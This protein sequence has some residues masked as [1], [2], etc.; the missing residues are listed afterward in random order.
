[1]IPE[2]NT[3]SSL[4]VW[5]IAVPVP[6]HKT[7]EYLPPSNA[8]P[9]A[10]GARVQVP[11]AGRESVG[12]FI[13]TRPSAIEHAQ[14]LKRVSSVL[15]CHS[16]FDQHQL[17]L[18]NWVSDYYLIPVG[19]ALLLGL[20]PQ[21]RKGK[22]TWRPQLD[23]VTRVPSSQDP[24]QVL[25]R[26][27][28]QRKALRYIEDKTRRLD[29]LE[30]QGISRST[31][32]A[33]L[34]TPFVE[35]VST[36][37]KRENATLDPQRLSSNQQRIV[38]KISESNNA[39]STHL[40]DGVTG[41][42]KTAIY[43][44]CIRR[45]INSGQQ[46]LVVV[47]EIGLTPQTQSRFEN[48]LGIRVPVI[49]SGVSETVRGQAWSM[50]RSGDA[51]VILGTR[52]SVFCS[53]QSLG[54]IVVDEEHDSSLR[55]QDSPR[56]SARD[57]AVKRAQICD[58]PVVLGSATPSLETLANAL[59]HRYQ[60]HRLTERATNAKLPAIRLVDTRGL[61]LSAGLS[62]RALTHI[63]QTV[64][65]GEQVLLFL[66]KRGFARSIRCEDCGWTAECNH[67]D[68]VMALHKTVPQLRC[69]HCL[70]NR[71]A[72]G[73]CTD[74]GS[75]RLT[76]KGVGTEQLELFLKREIAD[77]RLFRIDSDNVANLTALNAVLD[78]V[79][80]TP[81]A[82][83]L[84][85][86][87]L[88]KGHHFPRVTCVVVV[89]AD[90]LLFSPD[91]R[92]EER[93]FQLLTQVAGRSGRAEL[94]GEV[95]IQTRN[96][97]HPIMERIVDTPYFEIASMLLARR[98][99]LGLPPHGALGIIRTDTKDERNAIEFLSQLKE[100]LLQNPAYRLLG[101]MPALMTRRAGLFR[102]HLVVHSPSR[103]TVHET[104]QRAIDV[105]STLKIGRKM[106]WFVEID[107]TDIV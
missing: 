50:A 15:E 53:F 18:L 98:R 28:Q 84:G 12:I 2:T 37:I 64:A 34:K 72:P 55:Q 13:Q 3:N 25:A 92:A 47:P 105:G 59:T 75:I 106:T 73:S 29:E 74:C 40:V 49:H 39:F 51:P 35:K 58:C 56:Y 57:I 30:A 93:L 11:F 41:S 97:D 88:S 101:P 104:L 99:T 66:N 76:S 95:L 9:P 48:A 89:D 62:E 102:Y 80:Q 26:A 65:R 70:S 4:I 46:A 10:A 91:F 90:G 27:P 14:K 82:I 19:E 81:S 42:G 52:S 100:A 20:A 44:E 78:S 85:T 68:S 61:A 69:H 63:K 21:E 71:P 96:P 32:N 6:L 17:T 33:L 60:H 54:L 94:P 31:I 45:V 79:K 67:C 8:T 83:L 38:D 22:N 5:E 7:F 23:A 77:T 43:I 36:P 86:Q 16:L 103:K 107:P 24:E 1:M 87:M